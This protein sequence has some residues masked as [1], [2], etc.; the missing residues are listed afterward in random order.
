MVNEHLILAGIY[1]RN[2]H[3]NWLIGLRE[4][5]PDDQRAEA[6]RRGNVEIEAADKHL[7]MYGVGYDS[8][9]D[10]EHEMLLIH[11]AEASS[12]AVAADDLADETPIDFAPLERSYKLSLIV[13]TVNYIALAGLLIG[14]SYLCGYGAG[15][16]AVPYITGA[17]LQQQLEQYDKELQQQKE[18][19]DVK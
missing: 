17:Q 10:D 13:K 6:H 16:E 15:R 14:F 9:N 2:A 11:E 1:S 4:T 7:R 8:I 3:N 5:T 18:L 12:S 19:S